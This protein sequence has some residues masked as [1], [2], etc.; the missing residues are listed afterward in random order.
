MRTVHLALTVVLL[1]LTT[2]WPAPAQDGPG[3]PVFRSQI[4][5]VSLAAVVRDRHGHIVPSL[6]KADFRV[7]E[8]GRQ[9]PLLEVRSELDAPANIALL[10]DGSG[11]MRLKDAFVQARAVSEQI[12]N[13]LNEGRDEAALYSFDTRVLTLQPFTPELTKVR[14]SL[15]YLETWGSTSLYDAITGV[16]GKIHERADSRRAIVVFTDGNDTTSTVTPAEV[17]TITSALDVPVYVF[18]LN[19]SAAGLVNGKAP[20]PALATLAEATGGSYFVASDQAT[21]ASQVSTVIDE[22][23]HQHVLTFEASSERGWRSL[24]LRV[25]GRGYRIRTRGWYWAGDSDIPAT[26]R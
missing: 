15:G 20:V 8:N 16:A 6:G 19:P 9:V 14:R 26:Q 2:P 18:A 11:S 1:G 25:K 5:L 13:S 4:N 21:L 24:E 7:F 3:V 17:A 10:V 23:R 22:L 12:L